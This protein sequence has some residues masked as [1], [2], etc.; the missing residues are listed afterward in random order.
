[1]VHGAV[2]GVPPP[3]PGW[4]V[5][6]PAGWARI[7]AHRAFWA[8]AIR[9]RAAADTGFWAGVGACWVWVIFEVQG[10]TR[11]FVPVCNVEFRVLTE[12]VRRRPVM[13]NQVLTKA[14][15]S[16]QS[17]AVTSGRRSAPFSPYG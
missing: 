11:R 16:H 7:A 4:Q 15:L 2:G 17:N 10:F 8:C 3:A 1:V 13:S 5:P 9:L 12:G 14:L 6:A